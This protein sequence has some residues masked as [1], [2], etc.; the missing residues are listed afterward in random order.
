MIHSC[1]LVL[2]I[3]PCIF[4]SSSNFHSTPLQT[5]LPCN[6]TSTWLIFTYGWRYLS[7]V[8]KKWL[9]TT[10]A[11]FYS[12]YFKIDYVRIDIYIDTY[13]HTRKNRHPFSYNH[14]VHTWVHLIYFVYFQY[15][16]SI[17]DSWWPVGWAHSMWEWRPWI[18]IL[19]NLPHGGLKP[20]LTLV[21][22]R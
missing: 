3:H 21:V 11:T 9:V 8:P 16:I 10:K 6:Y 13:T 15:H 4:L 1:S 17:K 18:Q 19:P 7:R 22:R 12:Y 14:K 5:L 20:L 2:N